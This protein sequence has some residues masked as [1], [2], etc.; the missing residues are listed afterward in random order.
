M[1]WVKK[2]ISQLLMP[3]P[4][5]IILLLLAIMILR[6]RKLVKS[7]IV[8]ACLL[9]LFCSSQW[10]SYWLAS[11]LES[12]YAVNNQPM[13]S[14]CVVMV[15]GSGHD[16]AINA[17]ASQQL[18]A[19]ALAR[20]TEA[21][22]QL[23]LGPNC[24]LVVSGWGGGDKLPQAQVMA[25]AAIELGVD[26][27]R[28]IRLPLAK[29]TLEEA[30]HLQWEIGDVPFRLVTSATHLPRAMQIFT[31][32]GTQPQPAPANF[33]ARRGYWWQFDARNLLTSQQAI[34]EY[35]GSLWLKIKF[36]VAD[37]PLI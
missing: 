24:Q 19:I 30:Q 32:A 2:I 17:S 13:G 26:A 10:G 1:F 11:S 31:Q 36:A 20:L 27:A 15:L 29:D 6:R 22:R 18:S 34:H 14:G 9:L 8:S 28:I 21:V 23:T 33:I 4:L 16:S 37:E 3:V 25:Q 7:L 12:Q 35:V 5:T